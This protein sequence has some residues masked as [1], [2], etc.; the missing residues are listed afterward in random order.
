LSAD[1]CSNQDDE[2]GKEDDF[3]FRNKKIGE[4][5]TERFYKIT[6]CFGNAR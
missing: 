5:K 4:E 1:A 3:H 2:E 6:G